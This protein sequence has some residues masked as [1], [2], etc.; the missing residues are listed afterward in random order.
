MIIG[1]EGGIG[2]GKTLVMTAFLKREW[3]QFKKPLYANYKL[4]RLPFTRVDVSFFEETMRENVQFDRAAI[5]L[6][7][8]HIWLDSRTSVSKRNLLLSYFLLQTGKQG[9]NL[10]YT[11][12][13]F[14]QVDLRLRRRTDFA[15]RVERKGD[16][17]KCLVIDR[18]T[19]DNKVS[20]IA[21]YGPDFWEEFY[22][23]E[24]IKMV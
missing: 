19:P 2:Q 9:I 5:G 15:I 16:I 24:V 12:Q 21:V 1:I 22:T 7:E 8:M 18:T 3:T 23:K 13:D 20:R 6:D 17:H 4:K 10:Y 14:G 11:T